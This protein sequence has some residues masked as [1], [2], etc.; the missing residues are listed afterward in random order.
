MARGV[1]PR[2]DVIRRPHAECVVLRRER[3]RDVS[4]GAGRRRLRLGVVLLVGLPLVSTAAMVCARR[5]A[6]VCGREGVDLHD[7]RLAAVRRRRLR[8]PAVDRLDEAL[9]HQREVREVTH[10]HRRGDR[11]EAVGAAQA[12]DV[13]RRRRPLRLLATRRWAR[14]RRLATWRRRPSSSPSLPLWSPGLSGARS[15]VCAQWVCWWAMAMGVGAEHEARPRS[16]R[17][18]PE[19]TH[20]AATTS[21]R[22]RPMRS[23][24]AAC[25][26]ARHES[27][28][29]PSARV[30][31]RHPAASRE[32]SRGKA[33]SG[34][35]P[36]SSA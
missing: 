31:T 12:E 24:S 13:A 33:R 26:S 27:A 3:R 2:A 11:G 28:S 19:R 1:S 16:S 7:R 35:T 15:A 30:E 14:C 5:R 34:G 36:R 8:G 21:G 23:T 9:L 25:S 22:R 17:T 10:A 32:S 29:S 20:C 6:Q 18:Q 4:D